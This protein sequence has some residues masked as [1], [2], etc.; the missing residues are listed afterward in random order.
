MAK[1]SYLGKLAKGFV[2]SAVNQVGRDGGRVISNQ[3][4]GDAHS[5]PVRGTGELSQT[6]PPLTNQPYI[7][8]GNAEFVPTLSKELPL[9]IVAIFLTCGLASFIAFFKGLHYFKKD[10]VTYK[11]Y[12]VQQVPIY[13]RRYK[14]GIRGYK[15]EAGYKFYE[16]P[17]CQANPDDVR[18]QKSSARILMIVSGAV[19]FMFACALLGLKPGAMQ[20]NPFMLISIPLLAMYAYAM[21]KPE[22]AMDF[23][24]G[25]NGKRRII[26]TAVFL[27]LYCSVFAIK[28]HYY[29]SQNNG[30]VEHVTNDAPTQ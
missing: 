15:N 7:E 30:Q 10:T 27:I 1:Q 18:R 26:A 8:T 5:T 9:W 11:R 13:D 21:W 28:V 3:V 4:Y 20:F 22:A 14:S 19:L 29:P 12:E 17:A 6:P 16:I 24:N 2:R 23:V 25:S